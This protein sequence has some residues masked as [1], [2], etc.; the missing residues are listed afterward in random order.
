MKT[1]YIL[2]A[3]LFV[4]GLFSSCEDRLDIAKH[5]NM[6]SKEDFYQTD[7]DALE[8]I[9]AVYTSWFEGYFNWYMMKNALSDD[10]WTGGESR[11][12]NTDLHYLNEFTFGTD[13]GTIEGVYS[14]M[15]A[16]IYNANLVIEGVKPDTDV[17]SRAVAEAKFFRALAHFELISLWGNAPA[18]DHVLGTTE[19][20]QPT[21]NPET[22]WAL[23][24][25]DLKDA[26]TSKALPSKK[27][28]DDNETGIRITTET[29]KCYLGKAYVFQKKW[30]EAA[31]VL[32]EI[33]ESGLY[34]LYR[35]EY[36]D[37]LKMVANNSCES[38]LEG[39]FR[40]DPINAWARYNM[41]HIMTAWRGSSMDGSQKKPAYS[42]LAIDGYGFLN[43]RKDLYD[44]FVTREGADGYRL[45]QTMLTYT[46]VKNNIGVTLTRS[47]HGNEGYFMWKNRFLR[48][49]RIMEIGGF[50]VLQKVNNRV[51]RYAEILLL[52]AE[53]H[54]QNSNE[55]KARKY[56]N[57]I[58]KR[59]KLSELGTVTMNDIKVEKRLELCL[60]SVRYQDLVRWGDAP[61][62][63]GNQGKDVY[64]FDGTKASVEYSNTLYG[65]KTG[66]HELLPIP[67]KEIT[68]NPNM[69]QNPGWSG[70]N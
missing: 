27:N 60:E 10:V 29:A 52:A 32:D 67:S 16:I 57:E 21:G 47:M 14:N 26:I 33:I 25:S 42:D 37:I 48:S 28:K 64:T 62:A 38:I 31:K 18:I 11:G 63:L 34:D 8:A 35:G 53:A 20:H 43:P 61:T 65:F 59:S 1:K 41:I 5:G 51:M 22:T 13:H 44:A 54:M 3:V 46:Q 56:V 17:K 19:Y 66:K 24:E 30:D 50:N 6:G 45:N 36:Q 55:P 4:L 7:E 58:R 12:D 49:E 9:T 68:L 69:S 70:N 15:Y 2:V 23:I 40:N 39:Q